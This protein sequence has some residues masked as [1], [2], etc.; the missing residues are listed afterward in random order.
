MGCSSS[1][2][3]F[4]LDQPTIP[5]SV[6]KEIPLQPQRKKYDDNHEKFE[7]LMLNNEFSHLFF[8]AKIETEKDFS[9]FFENFYM[10]YY[11]KFSSLK[12]Q[13]DEVKDV[14]LEK[15]A[16]NEI[17]DKLRY[18]EI[19]ILEIIS[20]IIDCTEELNIRKDVSKDFA[21]TSKRYF[22]E[23]QKSITLIDR[24][25]D[26]LNWGI[27]YIFS[28]LKFNAQFPIQ[29]LKIILSPQMFENEHNIIDLSDIMQCHPELSSIAIV[30]Q[31]FLLENDRVDSSNF[32]EVPTDREID[33]TPELKHLMSVESILNAL[34]NHSNVNAFAFANSS[35]YQYK[36]PE[37]TK[38]SLFD[39]ILTDKLF[40]LCISKINLEIDDLK[41]LLKIIERLKNLKIIII[42]LQIINKECLDI[43]NECLSKNTKIMAC[44]IGGGDLLID[45]LEIESKIKLINPSFKFFHY[46][47]N[48]NLFD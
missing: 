38:K 19:D 31:K 41:Y 21:I 4:T 11:S 25:F 16:E 7:M 24:L 36:L 44:L 27:K 17:L 47:K 30:F 8:E 3:Q 37:N 39:L 5:S 35:N 46:V 34:K 48:L 23:R 13:K 18:K 12:L 9:N 32:S 42:D 29:A 10:K 15:I 6:K 40:S 1:N 20:E 33:Y 45:S 14:I 2:R 26:K 22:P 28:N 43:L